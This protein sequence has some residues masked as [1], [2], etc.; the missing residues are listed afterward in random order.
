M[1]K[2][3]SLVEEAKDKASTRALKL[4][5]DK[6]IS[7]VVAKAGQPQFVRWTDAARKLARV[8]RLDRFNR[9]ITIVPYTV[10]AQDFQS[11]ERY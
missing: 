10:P 8:I 1:T 6:Y 2:S 11:A 5:E 3:I 7:L 4:L 9:I